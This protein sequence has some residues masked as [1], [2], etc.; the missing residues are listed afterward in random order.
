M[1]KKFLRSLVLLTV[2]AV[3][4]LAALD[5]LRVTADRKMPVYKCGEAAS[6]TVT[7]VT[8][9]EN[10]TGGELVAEFLFG[11]RTVFKKVNIDFSKENP[12]KLVYTLNEPGFVLLRFRDKSGN[13][14]A[15]K[16]KTVLA[17]AGFEPEKIRKGY[18]MPSDFSAFWENNRKQLAATPVVLKENKKF[19]TSRYIAYDISVKSLNDETISGYLTVP[20]KKGKFPVYI[21][22]PGAGQGISS[23]AASFAR[24]DVITLAVNVHKFPTADNAAEQKKRYLADA[25]KN[26]YPYRGAGDRNK[27]FFVSVYAGIDRMINFIAAREEFDGKHMVIDG[28]SQGGGSALILTGLNKNITA[29]AANVPA[30]CDHGGHKLRRDPGWPKL[31]GQVKVDEFAPYFDAA[32]F[33]SEISVPVLMSCGFIDTTCSPSSVYAAFNELKGEKTMVHV[34]LEGHTVSGAY[35]KA[36]KAFLDKQLGL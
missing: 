20:R 19:S 24:R 2:F 4:P 21:M 1:R 3:L 28:S 6:F 16:K 27:F 17:G 25:K 33:A 26:Y 31:Y 30:L 32:V 9:K 15:V 23:P 11:G 36:N 13:L 35:V 29:A 7:G 18:D 14:F 5:D 12:V 34:P 10:A 22:V 8:G